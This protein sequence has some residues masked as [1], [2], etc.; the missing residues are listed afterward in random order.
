M[1]KSNNLLFSRVMALLNKKKK[2]KKAK[3]PK[4]NQN[5]TNAQ[6]NNN[7]KTFVLHL[8]SWPKTLHKPQVPFTQAR[9]LCACC[10]VATCRTF[11]PSVHLNDK[12]LAKPGSFSWAE[13]LNPGSVLLS[14]QR[15]GG[16]N[17]Q[18]RPKGVNNMSFIQDN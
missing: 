8:L 4:L 7:E 12:L 11:P 13:L 15:S 9:Q 6:T 16:H 18:F 3:K 10:K 17:K 5:Q 14:Q 1:Q 2:N